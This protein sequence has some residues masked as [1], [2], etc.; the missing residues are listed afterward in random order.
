MKNVFRIA[1]MLMTATAALAQEAASE[2]AEF[3]QQVVDALKKQRAA[4]AQDVKSNRELWTKIVAEL[5]AQ[6]ETIEALNKQVASLST[7]VNAMKKENATLRNTL[8]SEVNE[9]NL[10]IDEEAES[11]QKADAKIAKAVTKGLSDLKQRPTPPRG[12]GNTGAATPTGPYKTLQIAKG[13]T[14]SAISQATGVS[15]SKLK[16]FNGLTSDSIRV[17]QKLKIPQ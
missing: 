13:D 6:T 15:I 8:T 5:R 14:L 12:G 7:E 11:R 4:Y 9:V 17:G 10:R 16:K 3:R 2:D 1:V